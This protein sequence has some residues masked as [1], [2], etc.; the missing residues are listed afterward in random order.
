MLRYQPTLQ[1]ERLRLRPFVADDAETLKAIAGAREIADTSADVPHP[2]SLATAKS[3]IAGLPHFFR[4]Q[5]AVHF[6]MELRHPVTLIGCAGLRDIE[7]RDAQAQL[8]FWLGVAWWRCGYATEAAREL[9][10]FGFTELGLNR[11]EARPLLRDAVSLQV[12][13]KVGMKQE[14]ILRQARR[15]WD[16]F[17]D[18]AAH[19]LLRQEGD[20]PA[21]RLNRPN[22]PSPNRNPLRGDVPAELQ[23]RAGRL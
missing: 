20:V 23:N 16:V 7:A 19:A 4:T 3:W 12:L 6:A 14:G 9:L 2:Y 8:S 22:S 10:K 13:R 17:E 5:T 21:Q 18:V 11:I 1:T 15:K